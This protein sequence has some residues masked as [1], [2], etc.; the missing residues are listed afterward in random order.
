MGLHPSIHLPWESIG[1]HISV[2]GFG[3]NFRLAELL[4]PEL[5]YGPNRSSISS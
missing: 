5:I 4:G 2:D 3:T 1:A